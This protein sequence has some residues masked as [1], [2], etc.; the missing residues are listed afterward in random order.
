MNTTILRTLLIT[1]LLLIAAA[2]QARVG[3]T[4]LTWTDDARTDP[5]TTAPRR[6]VVQLWY[7]AAR[8]RAARPAPYVMEL[9][10]LRAE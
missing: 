9:D 8:D 7:P 10:A 5:V 4:K 6:V 3:T 2:A 1:A